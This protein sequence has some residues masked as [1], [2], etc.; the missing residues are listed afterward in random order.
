MVAETLDPQQFG[1]T[2][3]LFREWRAPRF[4]NDNPQKLNSKVWEWLMRSK[5][6]GYASTQIMNG[7]SAM[8]AGPTWSFDRFGQSVTALADGRT[9]YIGG[10]HEDHYDPDFYIYNDAVV[11]HPDGA[12]DFYCYRKSDFPPTDFHSAT[13][14]GDRI[15]ILGSLGYVEERDPGTTQLY[16]LDLGNFEIQKLEGS[17]ESP[18][19]IHSHNAILSEDGESI[20]L[21]EGKVFVG[22]GQALRENLDDWQLSLSDWR[23]ERLTQRNWTQFEVR[24]EDGTNLHLLEIRLALWSLM[25]KQEEQYQDQISRLS[26][27]LGAQPDVKRIQDLYRFDEIEHGELQKDADEY[28]LFYFEFD[29][30]RVRFTEGLHS[31]KVVVEGSVSEEKENLIKRGLLEKVSALENVPC[32]LEEY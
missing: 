32:E 8:E 4:G 2:P 3:E 13:L 31:L 5:L 10:E 9:V 7:P 29:G 19:W 27:A 26:E 1:V 25:M 30:V 17:G 15:V 22:Q 12:V 23:W 28:N 6:S 24:R 21:T 11:T 20:I 16:A 18:G 14:A